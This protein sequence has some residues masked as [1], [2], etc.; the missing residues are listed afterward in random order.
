MHRRLP[1]LKLLL[2][3]PWLLGCPRPPDAKLEAEGHY[4]KAQTAFLKGDFAEAHRCF[5]EVRRLAPTDPRLPAAEGEVYLAESRVD[6]ALALF[7]EA[8]AHDNQRATTWSRLGFLYALKKEPQKA[9]R[10]LDTALAKNPRDFNAL[11]SLADLDLEEGALDAGL[12]SLIEASRVAP[13]GAQGGLVLRAVA[14]LEKRKRDVE[15]LEALERAAD[16]GITSSEVMTEL[17]ELLVRAGR[18]DDAVLAYGSAATADPKDPTLWELVGALEVRLGRPSEAKVA[19]GKSL[20]IRDRSVVHVALA[21]LC[22][23]AKDDACVKGELDRALA[24]ATG[25]ELRETLE[26]AE[27]LSSVGRA[28]DALALLRT[29]SEEPDEKGNTELQ[30][31]TARLAAALKDR[32]TQKAACGRAVSGGTPGL[33]CP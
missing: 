10:A 21:R 6:E 17:G 27:L 16:G 23:A 9:R 33:R 14:E 1:S 25:E 4:L 20:A 18:F 8:L 24:T 19:Y 31:R 22:Q 5:A 12:R 3:V 30:L 26:L 11:E 28:K 7:E 32:A 2:L 13:G 15:A 29:V